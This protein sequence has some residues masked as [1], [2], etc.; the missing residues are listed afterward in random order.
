MEQVEI[1]K[2]ITVT[3]ELNGY[4]RNESNKYSIT[5]F[6]KT[7]KVVDNPSIRYFEYNFDRVIQQINAIYKLNPNRILKISLKT[8]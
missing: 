4:T 6:D 5:W 2:P 3:I 7:I 8:I 1:S